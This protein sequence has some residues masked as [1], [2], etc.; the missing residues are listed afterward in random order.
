MK[1]MKLSEIIGENSKLAGELKGTRFEISVLSNIITT[2]LNE[3]LEYSLRKS[4][5]NAF[6]TSGDYDNIVQDSSKDENAGLTIIFWEACNFVDGFQYKYQTLPD[7]TLSDL[8]VKIKSEMKLIIEN[9][10]SRPRV[11]FNTFSTSAFNSRNPKQNKFDFL[12]EELNQFLYVSQTPNMVIVDLEKIFNQA[13]TANSIDWRYF[14]SSKALYSVE[15]YKHYS[16]HIAPI[17]MSGLG[18]GKKVLVLDCDN[19]LWKGILGEDGF[20]GIEMSSSSK[21]GVYFEEIQNIVSRLAGEGVVVCLASKNNAADVDQVLMQH[22]DMVIKDNHIA[23]KKVNWNDKATNI[24]ELAE[25]LNL[26]LDSFV[27]VDDSD[28]EINLVR[29]KIPQVTCF[30]VPKKIYE[31]PTMFR[32]IEKLFFKLNTSREDIERVAMY[33]KEQLRVTEKS[34]FGNVEDYL[35][36]LALKLNVYIDDEKLIERIAQLTQKTNQFNLTTIRYSDTDIKGFIENPNNKVIAFGLADKFG[37]YGITGVSILKIDSE[38]KSASIDIFLMSCRI[39]GRNAE[40]VFFDYLIRILQEENTNTVKAKYL[41]TEKN[42]Q[43]E[44]FYD[45]LGFDIIDLSEDEKSYNLTLHSYPMHN[46]KYIEVI[47][48]RKS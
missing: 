27:F 41:K 29:E 5:I 42:S 47:D 10:K 35:S 13:T 3:I 15:F 37:D 45:K 46:I 36:S 2:Q 8:I 26:G 17:V 31:Y 20:D 32:E 22:K 16:L 23:A 19:T 7:A 38:T 28:F 43:V 44:S 1:E 25:E 6:V 33:K 48:G 24:K 4:G 9:L 14:Y 18:K 21:N 39:L 11:L 12:C 40:V 34:N 30:Q